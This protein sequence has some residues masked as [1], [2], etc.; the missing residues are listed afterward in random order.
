MLAC[1]TTKD[2]RGQPHGLCGELPTLSTGLR[3]M[4]HR[5]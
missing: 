5:E 4:L 3:D 1:D 2:I